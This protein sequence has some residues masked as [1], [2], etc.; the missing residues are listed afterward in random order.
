MAEQQHNIAPPFSVLA[1]TFAGETD[2]NLK[3]FFDSLRAQTLHA[4]EIVLV[5]D[6]PIS[7]ARDQ[8][9]AKLSNGLPLRQIATEKSSLGESLN[10]GLQHCK[11]DLVMRCDTDDQ[12]LPKRFETL[13]TAFDQ[14]HASVCSGPI[15]EF[16]S[17][18]AKQIRNLPRGHVTKRNF[19]SFFRS[20]IN[21]NNCCYSKSAVLAAGGYR[22][23][24]M[25]DFKLWVTMLRKGNTL[26]NV[27]EVLLHANADR[28]AHRRSGIDYFRAEFRLF[29]LNAPRFMGLGVFPA[30]A[31]FLIR[32][33]LRIPLTRPI[34]AFFYRTVL[35]KKVN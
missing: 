21:H 24:R 23:G 27:D 1:V 7:A 11:F 31:S 14:N 20:P 29:V 3:R 12:N 33:P 16:Q 15:Q 4:T 34:L 26:F 35:R 19:S 18:G 9:L 5:I 13:V 8:L 2:E 28:I 6:G 17:N 10:T 32:A 22:G 30:I 25:E